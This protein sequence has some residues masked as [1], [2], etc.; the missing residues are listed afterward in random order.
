MLTVACVLR[1]GGVYDATWVAR[2]AA[3]VRQHLAEPHLFVCLTDMVQEVA[4]IDGVDVIALQHDWPG[5][6]AKIEIFGLP[7]PVLFFDLDTLPL[8]DLTGLAE[9]AKFGGF[10]MLQDFYRPNGFGS[11]VMAWSADDQPAGLLN[12]FKQDP[13]HWIRSCRGGDQE[14]VEIITRKLGVARW[15][16]ALPGQIVSYKADNCAAAAPADA[17]VM[18]LHGLPKF[19]DM[20]ADSWA[21]LAWEAL[22]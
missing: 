13:A 4:A 1:S 10:T 5:W 8:G 15:Q 18:C 21:R 19:S 9:Q 17:R 16:D 2:L 20:P 7:G 14:F 12:S 6:W 3:A 22:A 11:G